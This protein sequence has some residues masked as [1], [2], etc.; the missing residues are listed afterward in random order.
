[1]HRNLT[2]IIA[3]AAFMVGA[4]LADDGMPFPGP[5]VSASIVS[6]SPGQWVIGN[7]TL[8]ATF[9]RDAAGLRLATLRS[10]LN[11]LDLSWADPNL[12][13]IYLT[14]TPNPLAS[15]A[16]KLVG[17]PGQ[18]ALAGAPG[19]ARLAQR[20]AGRVLRA[21]F[22]DE[23]SGLAV[24]WRAIMTDGAHYLRQEI[25]LRATR[26]PVGVER[27]EMLRA[28]LPDAV[29][30]GYTDG[31]VLTTDKLFL[32]VEHPMAGNTVQTS[33]G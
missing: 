2:Y 3:L 4:A 14:G 21:T 17:E 6:E 28:P 12:F 29:V 26:A 22:T 23:A 1:M 10:P 18:R 9:I 13:T 33:G 16:M 32:G 11:G 15:S 7:N 24:Q 20:L 27:I 31:A 25:T 30:T 19:E 8:T 5:A